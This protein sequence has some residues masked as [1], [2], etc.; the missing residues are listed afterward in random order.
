MLN[1]SVTDVPCLNLGMLL[2]R[3]HLGLMHRCSVNTCWANGCWLW[4]LMVVLSERKNQQSVPWAWSLFWRTQHQP[5]HSI[6]LSSWAEWEQ[7]V[8]LLAVST[9]PGYSSLSPT[10]LLVIT[11]IS[12]ALL[13][14]ASLPSYPVVTLYIPKGHSQH[15]SHSVYT[16]I[17]KPLKDHLFQVD[18]KW[19]LLALVFRL[20]PVLSMYLAVK[21][22]FHWSF[23]SFSILSM[24]L[25]RLTV[26]QGRARGQR[27]VK[28]KQALNQDW[29][30]WLTS[31]LGSAWE[32]M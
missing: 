7:L 26:L 12:K 29:P 16:F 27:F 5:L 25:R 21:V 15:S 8:R 24:A 10:I 1:L 28:H 14:L 32:K 19:V 20:L 31:G 13:C 11:F 6:F 30:S 3:Q 4:L 18:Q 23:I 9:N 2:R 17:Q 22:P